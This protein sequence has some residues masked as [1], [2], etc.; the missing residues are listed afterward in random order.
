MRISDCS[1]DACS[2]DLLLA[3]VSLPTFDPY[4]HPHPP[5]RGFEYGR[6]KV[7]AVADMFTTGGP[8]DVVALSVGARDGIDT[9]TVFSPWRSDERSVG[10]ACG[11]PGRPRGWADH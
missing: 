11:G 7:L 6:A 5:A 4:F 8:H 9:G 10:K 3:M 1:S 2:S